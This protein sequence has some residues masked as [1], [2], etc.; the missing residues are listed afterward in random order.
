[1]YTCSDTSGHCLEKSADFIFPHIRT[2]AGAD[3]MPSLFFGETAEIEP[4]IK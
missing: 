4:E 2:H 1:M 3:K